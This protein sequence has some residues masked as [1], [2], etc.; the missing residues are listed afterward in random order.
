MIDGNFATN[1]KLY[2][3]KKKAPLLGR[4]CNTQTKL[5]GRP[6]RQHHQR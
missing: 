1:D 6:E 3:S 5:T 2:R 4:F